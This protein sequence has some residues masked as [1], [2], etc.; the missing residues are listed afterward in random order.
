[1]PKGQVEAALGL[2]P[3]A[4]AADAACGAAPGDAHHPAPLVGQ[5]VLLIKD[6]SVV[7]AIGLTDLTRV[8]WLV[9]QRV[10]TGSW[11]SASSAS[12]YFIVC[13]PLLAIAAGSNAAWAPPMP[14][15]SCDDATA[16][17]PGRHQTVIEFRGVNKWFGPLHVLREGDAQRAAEGGGGGLRASGSARAR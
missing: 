6:S 15:S 13:Y 2:R 7:S 17:H 14:R 3:V 5:Y 4:V 12:A 16:A 8:G 11:S 9:V 1:V 10:P